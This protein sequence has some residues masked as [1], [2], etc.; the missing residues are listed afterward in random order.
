M[1]YYSLV[2]LVLSILLL[3]N[4]SSAFDAVSHDLPI[5]CLSDVGTSGAALSWFSSDLTDRQFYISVQDFGSPTAHLKQGAPQGS[6]LGPLLFF[7]IY[8][9]ALHQI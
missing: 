5:N 8:I 1:I 3:L 7:I 9:L 2:T 4:L 6:I